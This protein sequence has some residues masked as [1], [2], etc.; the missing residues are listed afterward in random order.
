MTEHE[1][2]VS[3]YGPYLAEQIEQGQAAARA[4]AP[5]YGSKTDFSVDDGLGAPW[6]RIVNLASNPDLLAEAMRRQWGSA[7]MRGTNEPK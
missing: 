5:Q 3:A 4:A 2:N 7:F 1:I 6:T